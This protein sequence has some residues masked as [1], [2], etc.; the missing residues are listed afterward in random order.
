MKIAL[1]IIATGKYIQFLPGLLKSAKAFFCTAHDVVFH[2]FSDADAD[3]LPYWE[4]RPNF[5]RHYTPHEPWPGPTLHR[6]RTMLKAEKQLAACDYV[7]YCDVDMRFEAPIGD[8]V[9]GPGLTATLHPGFAD[10]PRRTFTYETRLRSH[11]YIGPYEGTRYFCGGFQG[12]R[13]DDYLEA[14]ACM[15]ARIECD[16]HN[17]ITAA[18]HD[19][20]HW[21]RYLVDHPPATVLPPL[22]CSPESWRVPGRKIVAIDKNHAECRV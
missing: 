7:F 21:N 13:A 5:Q 6:Y 10:K 1:C 9:M 17:D 19:E 14:V 11:A 16:H 22:Y 8:E 15:A 18:W 4:Y 12:G 2:V 20:S 3:N